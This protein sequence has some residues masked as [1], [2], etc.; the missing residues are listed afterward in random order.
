MMFVIFVLFTSILLVFL[1]MFIFSIEYPNIQDLYSIFKPKIN[2]K[3]DLEIADRVIKE[4]FFNYNSNIQD[5]NSLVKYLQD[6]D[7]TLEVLTELLEET[8]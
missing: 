2:K 4:V 6:S 1:A 5:L 7:C 3:T 8:K